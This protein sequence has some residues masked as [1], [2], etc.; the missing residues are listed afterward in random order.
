MK[1]VFFSHY[2]TPEG[3]APAS[4][5][6]D[7]CARWA[8]AGHEVTVITCAPNVPNGEVYEGY[9]NGLWP[10]RE[11]IDGIEVVRVWTRIRPKPGKK[12][13]ILNFLSY[14]FSALFAFVFFVRRP[15]VIVATSPQFF[16]GVAGVLASWLKWR[17][18]VLEIRDI[19]PES[20][21]T[22]GAMGRSPIIRALEVIER[23]MYRNAS[24]IVA[25][26]SGYRTNIMKKVGLGDRISVITNGVDPE[27]FTPEERCLDIVETYGLQGKFICSYVGT[28]G[29][30][31]GLDIVVRTAE[32][33]R[34]AGR[35]D[36][37]FMVVG[38]GAKLSSLRETVS[39]LRLDDFIVMTGHL[40]KPQM[41]KVLATSDACLVHLSNVA[42]FA[43]VI[44]SKI[45][46]TM[47][48]E[49]P[50]IMG[51]KG[52]A[53]DI[54]MMAGGGVAVEP[55]DD[56]E[57]FNAVLRLAEDPELARAMGSD[58][59]RFALKHFD[60]N[61]L[62]ATYLTLLREVASGQPVTTVVADLPAI[63]P[64]ERRSKS[65]SSAGVAAKTQAE[66][67]G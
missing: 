41:P 38:G 33:L 43:T 21:L 55:E 28:V 11:T 42:L 23:W 7:H 45:F 36:V 12:D 32:R 51:V 2:F 29:L 5:T 16:C 47:A 20:I 49:R 56:A 54:V 30:A 10:V 63:G 46:E 27:Q 35:D 14:M 60:R 31:H 57:L 53:R 52:P 4:R 26:G 40:D 48:M 6:H 19:W 22:V 3:N 8:A 61:D 64:E 39:E 65:S 15:N 66:Q 9:S 17:P 18:L 37:V 13:L 44:P 58:A 34:D 24:H 62:A 1:I 50:I 59:R 67:V 25:V